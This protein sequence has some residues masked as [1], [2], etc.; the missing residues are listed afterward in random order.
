VP[1]SSRVVAPVAMMALSKVTLVDSPPL[2]TVSEVASS[3]VAQPLISVI[4]F[5]FIRKW[6]PLTI[7]SATPRLRL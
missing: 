7:R 6:T 4:L 3:N 1:G 2:A 5:F